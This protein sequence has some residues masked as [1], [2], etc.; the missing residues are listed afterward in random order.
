ME[1]LVQGEGYEMSEIGR[2]SLDRLKRS[3]PEGYAMLMSAGTAPRDERGIVLAERSWA[4]VPDPASRHRSG[5]RIQCADC[6]AEAFFAPNSGGRFPPSAA[7]THFR[8]DG[9]TVGKGPRRD[10]CPKCTAK[11]AE[12][13]KGSN[14]VELPKLKAPE[15]R[16]MTRDDRRLIVAEIKGCWDEEKAR[17]MDGWHD[18]RIAQTLGSHVPKAWVTE[19]REDYFGESGSNEQFDELMRKTEAALGDMDRIDKIV[20]SVNELVGK[21]RKQV[22]DLSLL[23]KDVRRAIGR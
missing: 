6:N 23:A 2:S 9:W 11:Q 5:I 22:D 4:F 13:Q 17:Y 14:V 12:K 15:P 3:N 10:F 1:S 16:S 18:E 19:V 21:T 7:E 20:Q 8:R